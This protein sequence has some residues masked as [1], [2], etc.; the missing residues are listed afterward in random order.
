MSA[1]WSRASEGCS[2][3][4]SSKPAPPAPDPGHPRRGGAKGL[5]RANKGGGHGGRDGLAVP[6][7][8]YAPGTGGSPVVALPCGMRADQT[9]L[10]LFFFLHL[11][12]QTRSRR[13]AHISGTRLARV[14]RSRRPALLRNQKKGRKNMG[15][16]QHHPKTQVV[17]PI[18]GLI[19]VAVRTA[20]VVSIVVP[21]T[22]AHDLPDRLTGCRHPAA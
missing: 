5:S 19:P 6:R 21:G 8:W 4:G 2:A 3:A 15:R 10:A 14:S 7:L 11:G 13:S 1:G 12:G 9:C 22:A 18:I 16:T 20:R 17:V